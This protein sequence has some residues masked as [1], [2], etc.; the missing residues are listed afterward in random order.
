MK[1]IDKKLSA[2]PPVF[3]RTLPGIARKPQADIERQQ[4]GQI[5]RNNTVQAKLT[6]GQPNDR[7]EQEADRVADEVMSMPD[8]PEEE[9]EEPVQTKPLAEGVTPL[10]QR[11][12]EPEEEEEEPVQTKLLAEGI[13]P[14]V[15]RQEEP[16]EEEEEA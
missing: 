13:T 5:L 1:T 8:P 12:E 6:I 4:I 14:L 2:R 7:Y 10:V 15:Q 16:E 3:H 9:E 11:Q